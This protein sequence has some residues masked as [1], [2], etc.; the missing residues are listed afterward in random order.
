MYP[1]QDP[2]KLNAAAKAK[3]QKEPGMDPGEAMILLLMVVVCLLMISGIMVWK[4]LSLSRPHTSSASILSTVFLS[5]NLPFYH[6]VSLLTHILQ[7]G[8]ALFFGARFDSLWKEESVFWPS[9][10]KNPTYTAPAA[11]VHSEL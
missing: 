7:I 2:K 1:K 11:P 3:A 4:I 9:N 5:T 10:P 6:F 8:T